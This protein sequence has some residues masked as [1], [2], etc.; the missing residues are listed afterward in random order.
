MARGFSQE[1]PEVGAVPGGAEGEGR[2]GGWPGSSFSSGPSPASPGGRGVRAGSRCGPHGL[3]GGRLANCR[4]RRASEGQLF[5]G[6]AEGLSRRIGIDV[7]FVRIGFVLAALAGFGLPLYVILWFVLPSDRGGPNIARRALS[8]RRGIL[9]VLALVPLLAVALLV[10][11]AFRDSSLSGYVWG[12][13]LV[14]GAVVL[15]WRNSSD[16]ERVVLRSIARPVVSLGSPHRSRTQVAL[17]LAAGAACVAGGLYLVLHHR[18]QQSLFPLGGV[19]LVLAGV[20]V[21]F[22]P[23]WM[24]IARDLV[25]ERQARARAEERAD[26]AARVH[27]SVLQ[28]LALIQR[29]ADQPAQV[30]AL[31]RAQERELRS[32]LFDGNPPGF[33]G[34]ATTFT[35]GLALIQREVEAAYEITVDAVT[36]GDCDLDDDVDALLAATREAI[37]NAA[38][39][40][41]SASVSVFAEVT[42]ELVSV[43]VRDRGRGFQPAEVP[44]DRR[45]VSES[46]HA[47]MRRHNGTASV[48][49][50][51]GQGTEVAL[52]LPRERESREREAHLA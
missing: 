37:V 16:D 12:T 6:V 7:T 3:S 39:W 48:R 2:R 26:M 1:S 22:G 4:L 38:K 31:A 34:E 24:R 29:R 51:P 23:W 8:D 42:P 30:V 14:I 32:W 18:A 52:E 19:L 43:F 40:S 45:G 10:L 15:V 50:A 27:D 28:T 47:R 13:F 11:S 5:G 20:V 44:G 35:A 46:I 41:G 9:L 25:G 33:L 17:W 36:V 21:L 49:S